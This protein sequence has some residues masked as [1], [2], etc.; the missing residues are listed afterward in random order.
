[1][2]KELFKETRYADLFILSSAHFYEN[3]GEMI[4]EDYLDETLH[5]AECPVILLP[6]SFSRPDSIILAYDGSA[7]SMHAIKQ[8]IYLFPQWTDLNTLVVY[9]DDGKGEI[10]FYPL[11]REYCAQHFSKLAYYK[12]SLDPKKYFTTWISEKGPALLISG[13]YGRSAFSE[14]FHKSFLRDVV[15]AQQVP[16]FIAHL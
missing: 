8:F 2:V 7:S 10:P 16:V 11:I 14:L 3:L 15:S 6:G 9:A 13:A 1:V 5:K 4:Q 12:L